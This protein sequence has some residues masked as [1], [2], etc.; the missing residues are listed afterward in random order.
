MVDN[1]VDAFIH[2]LCWKFRNCS[3]LRNW[4]RKPYIHILNLR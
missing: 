4:T 3:L 2:M 1:I